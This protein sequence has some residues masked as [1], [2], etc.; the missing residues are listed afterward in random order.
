LSYFSF[1]KSI[2]KITSLFLDLALHEREAPVQLKDI[3][4]R[5]EISVSYLEHLITPLIS[6][7]IVRATRGPKGGVSLGRRPEKIKL[8]E[9]V[10][11]LEGAII[12]V[13]CVTNPAICSRSGFCVT[14][15]IW[16]ELK[17]A[18]DEVLESQ[19]LRDLIERQGK[20]Q[21]RGIT[22]WI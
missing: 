17:R 22:Y 12:I 4:R 3:A 9:V 5:Q 11:L 20:V 21:S 14:R 7:G 1:Y 16:T 18:V 8:S 19:T 10:E 15:D 6:G 2:D 13:A